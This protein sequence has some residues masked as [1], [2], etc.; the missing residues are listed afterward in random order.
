MQILDQIEQLDEQAID[1]NTVEDLRQ[2]LHNEQKQE[3]SIII[4]S[5]ESSQHRSRTRVLPSLPHVIESSFVVGT[6]DM[7]SENISESM[8]LPVTGEIATPVDSKEEINALLTTIDVKELYQEIQQMRNS[9]EIAFEGP[10]A[11]LDDVDNQPLPMRSSVSIEQSEESIN[12]VRLPGEIRR[13]SDSLEMLDST[14]ISSTEIA[15]PTPEHDEP[16]PRL[17]LVGNAKKYSIVERQAKERQMPTL[18][19]RSIFLCSR[20]YGDVYV[21][22]RV[23]SFLEIILPQTCHGILAC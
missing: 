10:R 19:K 3:T 12:I 15:S 2:Q 1:R 20:D 5:K 17:L 22:H 14:L 7:R 23:S 13:Q 21:R 18:T 11:P 9:M 16:S 8:L 4:L 6:G